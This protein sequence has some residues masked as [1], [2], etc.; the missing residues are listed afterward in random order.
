[1]Y[2][3]QVFDRLPQSQ[4]DVRPP[5]LWVEGQIGNMSVRRSQC[6]Q[7][8]VNELRQRIVD[9]ALQEWAYF[10]YRMYRVRTAEEEALPRELRRQRRP[11]LDQQESIRLASSIAGYWS[12]TAEGGWIVERQNERWTLEGEAARWR[13]AWSAAFVSWVMCEAG[14]NS[15]DNFRHAI[16]HHSYIDQAIR[17]R[18][19]NDTK[20]LFVAYDAGETNVEL[21]DLLCT[22]TRPR[23][24]TLAQRRA[25]LGEGARTHCDIVVKID[26]QANT[27]DTIGGNVQSAVTLK[28]HWLAKD[29]RI[30]SPVERAGRPVFAHLKFQE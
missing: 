1:M 9:I 13:D 19:E 22:G 21:G 29:G 30:L 15:P 12:A 2:K 27:I 8:P 28:R 10:G 20:S 25:Q 18:D 26:K 5:S 17:A 7:F 3:R 14:I 24:V 16:A 4:F 11:R 23:Y 6:R